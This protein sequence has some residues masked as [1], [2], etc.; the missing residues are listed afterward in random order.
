VRRGKGNVK[1]KA[2]CVPAT[3]GEVTYRA[4]V[5]ESGGVKLTTVCVLQS[6]MQRTE[7]SDHEMPSRTGT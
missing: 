2:D 1:S 6:E 4:P 5:T 7:L 3:E